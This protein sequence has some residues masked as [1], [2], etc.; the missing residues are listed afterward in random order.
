MNTNV[1]IS[2]FLNPGTA[3]LG[4]YEKKYLKTTRSD[5]KSSVS[6]FVEES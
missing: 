1:T 4:I 6:S 2:C 3:E 5:R